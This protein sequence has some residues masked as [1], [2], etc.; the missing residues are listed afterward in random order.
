MAKCK[1]CFNEITWVKEGRKNI[2]IEGDGTKHR[3]DEMMKSLGSAKTLDR[4]SLSAEEI[5][6]YEAAI[7]KKK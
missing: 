1:F 7:N 6:K 2:P 5:A 3:C 4:N